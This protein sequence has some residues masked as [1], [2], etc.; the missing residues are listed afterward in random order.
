MLKGSI[1]Y[2]FNVFFYQNSTYIVSLIVI[3]FYMKLY[4]SGLVSAGFAAVA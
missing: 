1:F 2:T 4:L 3:I